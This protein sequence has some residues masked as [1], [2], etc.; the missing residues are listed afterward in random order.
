MPDCRNQ[1][2]LAWRLPES[3]GSA[4]TLGLVVF[5]GCLLGIFTRPV[6]FLASFWPA[7]ALML[8]FLLRN[9]SAARPM[10]WLC[11]SLG[12]MAA[13][14][15]TGASLQKAVILNMGN[16]LG[17]AAGY[18]FVRLRGVDLIHLRQPMAMLHLVAACALA[19]AAASL[20]G[21]FANPLLFGGGALQGSIFWLAG[22]FVNY[23]ALMP[24]LLSAPSIGT[25]RWRSMVVSLA[26]SEPSRWLPVVALVASCGV[27]QLLGGPGSVAFPV[28]ALLWCGLAYPVFQTSILTLLTGAWSLM[29][30]PDPAFVHDE[31]WVASFRLGVSLISAAPIMLSCV[32]QSRN[33]LL[34]RL[35]HLATHDGLTGARSRTAFHDEAVRL[36]TGGGRTL[37]ILMIDLDRFKTVNDT[38]GHAGGDAVLAAVGQRIQRCLRATDLFGRVGGEEFA[39]AISGHAGPEL[40]AIGERIRAAVASS[41]VSVPTGDAILVTVS[42][43]AAI[44]EPAC[45]RDLERLL[46][47]ADTA[48]YQAKARGRDRI[49]QTWDDG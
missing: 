22:E 43:G 33:E 12:F 38:Y 40:A 7:N 32:M 45:A 30:L 13:D 27:A 20:V 24:V 37:G 2:F 6:G 36:A 3:A 35:H 26:Q 48:L 9:P 8:G 5:L 18:L 42:I 28:P 25:G 47:E 11:A 41:P 39:V 14:L 19:S 49:V 15:L 44:G 29:I 46:S 34:T 10:G 16:V 1:G 21:S 17:V 23:M 4:A 31:I